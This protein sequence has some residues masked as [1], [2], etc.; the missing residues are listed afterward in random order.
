MS[1][2]IYVGLLRADGT[3][4]ENASGYKRTIVQGTSETV[5]QLL[6][7]GQIVFPDVTEPGY[8]EIVCVA[9]WKREYGGVSLTAWPLPEPVTVHAGVVPVIHKGKLLMGVDVK[10]R[11]IVKPGTQCKTG[12]VR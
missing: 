10:A 5:S 12:G 7:N 9:A 4:P 1:E 2:Y 6:Q 3:E 11:C 8:G